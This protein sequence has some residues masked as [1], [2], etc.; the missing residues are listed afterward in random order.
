MNSPSLDDSD[1]VK[2]K[3]G[4][5]ELLNPVHSLFW[6]DPELAPTDLKKVYESAVDEERQYGLFIFTP[7]KFHNE[8]LERKFLNSAELPLPNFESPPSSSVLYFD[9]F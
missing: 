9:V 5:F 1:V 3:D 2:E 7:P 6:K 8:R 4:Y